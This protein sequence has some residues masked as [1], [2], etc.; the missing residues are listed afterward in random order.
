MLLLSLLKLCPAE[1]PDCGCLNALCLL[2]QLGLALMLTPCPQLGLLLSTS[3]QRG[4]GSMLSCLREMGQNVQRIGEEP[5]GEPG[6]PPGE[7]ATPVPRL[8]VRWQ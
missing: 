5:H 3:P 2:C 6:A 4:C 1:Q 8:M 7:V